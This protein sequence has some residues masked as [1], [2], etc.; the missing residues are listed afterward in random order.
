MDRRA[1]ETMIESGTGFWAL[2]DAV[3]VINL[4]RRADRWAEMQAHLSQL[5]PS[6]KIHR[7][8]AV[9][10]ADLPGYGKPPWFRRNRRPATWAGRAGC[11]LSHRNALRLAQ[12]RQWHRILIL[13]DD[14]R[15]S[16]ELNGDAGLRLSEL[17]TGAERPGVCYLGY[18]SPRG[19][20]RL[21]G[22]LDNPPWSLR[23]ERWQHHPCLCSV[24][25]ALPALAGPSATNR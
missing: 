2:I 9:L 16:S 11:I 6:D 19:P 23:L 4:D 21:I 22:N 12:T 18:T 17:L 1:L 7:L 14:A 3:L 13:E 8:P 10:G 25:R 15:L 5:A 24:R 20:T